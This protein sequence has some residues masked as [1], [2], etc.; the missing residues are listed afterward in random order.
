MLYTKSILLPKEKSDGIRIS[1]MSRHTYD[2]GKTPHPQITD[3]SYDRWLKK[4]APPDTLVGKYLRKEISWGQYRDQYLLFLQG[5]DQK[6]LIRYIAK[7]A[8]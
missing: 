8:L 7:K 1:V 3:E 5:R 4:L 6:K 2:D